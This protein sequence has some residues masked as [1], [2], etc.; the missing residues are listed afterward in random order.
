MS[1]DA[2]R[3]LSDAIGYDEQFGDPTRDEREVMRERR[4]QQTRAV[5]ERVN[6]MTWWQLLDYDD[7]LDQITAECAKDEMDAAALRRVLNAHRRLVVRHQV[8]DL[9]DAA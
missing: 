4:Q 8:A 9:E 3:E 6:A 7:D 5:I 1:I 2:A